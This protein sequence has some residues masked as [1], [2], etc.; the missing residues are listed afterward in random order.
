AM[1]EFDPI[2]E[3]YKALAY[4]GEE[5]FEQARY[6][7]E[8]A[9]YFLSDQLDFLVDYAKFLREEGDRKNLAIII[10]RGLALDE[11]DEFF[12]ELA[13]EYEISTMED[14]E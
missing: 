2:L 8:Q 13:Q 3:W 7:F 5:E 10:Q 14:F 1:G 4:N 11:T 12:I 9:A 6:Q